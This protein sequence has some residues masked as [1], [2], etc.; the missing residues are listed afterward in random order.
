LLN[1]IREYRK[2]VDGMYKLVLE[3]GEKDYHDIY[4]D[5]SID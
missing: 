3:I 1:S 4:G 2:A 5:V